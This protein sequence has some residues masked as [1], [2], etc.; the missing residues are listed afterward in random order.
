MR[1][2]VIKYCDWFTLVL[3]CLSLFCLSFSVAG[4]ESFL[5]PAIVLWFLKRAFGYRTTGP[6]GLLPR[7]KINNMLFFFLL[8]NVAATIASSHVGLSLRALFGKDLRYL[9]LYFMLVETI[10]TQER[11][12]IILMV[13][14][15]SAIFI[16]ADTVYQLCKGVD[17]IRGFPLGTRITGPFNNANDFAGWLTPVILFLFGLLY[18][19]YLNRYTKAFF[20]LVSVVLMMCLVLTYSRGAWL[21]LVV[22]LL[23]GTYY[24]VRR[25]T[26]KIKLILLALVLLCASGYL[27]NF[28]PI[29]VMIDRMGHFKAKYGLSIGQRIISVTD[30]SF[31]STVVR[32]RLWKQA[33]HIIQQHPFWGCGLNNYF[34]TVMSYKDFDLSYPHNSYLQ[35]AAET[36][37]I[38]LLFFLWLVWEYFKN[39]LQYVNKHDNFLVLGLLCGILAF[40]I[41]SF[42]DTNLYALRLVVLFWF[43]LGLA[44]A[45]MNMNTPSAHKNNAH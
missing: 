23:L 13:L 36:G 12:R 20:A 31:Y 7:T 8:A 32:M 34:R 3:L 25:L 33:F 26:P 1:D 44:M 6:W 18:S 30:F 16:S 38:G 10:I 40:L 19:A 5:W 21:G 9:I 35:M 45:V 17:F 14:L 15:S 42:F 29:N 4:L 28:H 11:L 39:G 24:V 37:I 27:A 41:Q 22:G 43:M 2:Q